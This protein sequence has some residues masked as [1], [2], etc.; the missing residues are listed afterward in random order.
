[1]SSF[2]TEPADYGL[3]VRQEHTQGCK[4]EA[5]ED[6]RRAAGKPEDQVTEP[7]DLHSPHSAH[8]A[9]GPPSPNLSSPGLCALSASAQQPPHTQLDS[10]VSDDS[11][12]DLDI[13]DEGE[14]PAIP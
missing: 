13:E 2:G 5:E 1:M 8:S 3:V 11:D 9:H 6:S 10:P 4:R 14:L 7:S 12:R